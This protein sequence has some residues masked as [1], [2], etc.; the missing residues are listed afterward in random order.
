MK[1]KAA[2]NRARN[3]ARQQQ[4]KKQR[5]PDVRKQ[6]LN[7][8]VAAVKQNI[9]KLD[10]NVRCAIKVEPDKR[11]LATFINKPEQLDVI[12]FVFSDHAK[13]RKVL[14]TDDDA[15]L[16]DYMNRVSKTISSTYKELAEKGG[17]VGEVNSDSDRN[18][19]TVWFFSLDVR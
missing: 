13:W 2:A 4:L 12:D 9:G 6:I 11:E 16:T 10:A 8:L 19:N 3:M 15:D 5:N 14:K 1:D 17:W 7:T 18:G